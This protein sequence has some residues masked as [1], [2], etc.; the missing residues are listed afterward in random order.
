M[1]RGV[2]EMPGVV[3][4]HQRA[5]VHYKGACLELRLHIASFQP[6]TSWRK[7]GDLGLSLSLSFIVVCVDFVSFS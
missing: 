4:G 2:V 5:A 7:E 6:E 1:I 3:R